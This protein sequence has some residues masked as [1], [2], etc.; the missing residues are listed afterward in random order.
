MRQWK[1]GHRQEGGGGG[2]AAW[3]DDTDCP[4]L[5]LG[6]HMRLVLAL[7]LPAGPFESDLAVLLQA[8]RAAPPGRSGLGGWVV[9]VVIVGVVLVYAV[10]IV[11]IVDHVGQ[12]PSKHQLHGC[13]VHCQSGARGL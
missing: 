12:G 4:F 1:S 6:L 8:A 11:A 10:V 5:R 13:R 7:M 9:F 3:G 2:A